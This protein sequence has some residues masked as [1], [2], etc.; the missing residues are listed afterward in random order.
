VIALRPLAVVA[1][2]QPITRL[3]MPAGVGAPHPAQTVAAIALAERIRADARER[4]IAAANGLEIDAVLDAIDAIGAATF[5]GFE[6]ELQAVLAADAGCRA[7]MAAAQCK[8]GCAFCCHVDVVAT[9]L[10]AIRIATAMRRGQI[11]DRRMAIDAAAWPASAGI[12]R[13]APCP[14][15]ADNMC[16]VYAIRPFACRSLFSLDVRM[17]EQGFV[18]GAA[19]GA[20]VRVPTLAWPRLLSMG[21]LTG[22]AAAMRDLGLVARLVEL[23]AALALLLADGSATVRWLNGDD[24]FAPRSS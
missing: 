19:P 23:R 1:P 21:Y 24:V 9:P 18:A 20:T 14:L 22:L 16:S 15:L 7:K 12:A 10:E 17:C 11:P 8:V 4:L 5:S 2:Q 3:V 13:K 6:A